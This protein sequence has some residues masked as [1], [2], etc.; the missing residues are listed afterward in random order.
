M[1]FDMT[2]DGLPI[3]VPNDARP[4]Q[5]LGR[6]NRRLQSRRRLIEAFS[7][8][9]RTP[10][11][12]ISQY[13]DLLDHELSRADP[14]EQRQIVRV[15][16]DRAGD[17]NHTFNNLLDA[18]KVDVGKMGS[19]RRTCNPV[20]LTSAVRSILER[21]A[22]ALSRTLEFDFASD[23]APIFCDADQ[24]S[25]VLVNLA[26]DALKGSTS[27]DGVAVWATSNA[28]QSG[29]RVGVTVRRCAGGL[30]PSA[31]N[32]RRE[33]FAG[34]PNTFFGPFGATGRV[35]RAILRRNLTARVCRTSDSE[36]CVSI[37][38]PGMNPEEIV[39]RYLGQKR[40]WSNRET[41]VTFV[42]VAG[43]A[44]RP[45]SPER[46]LGIDQPGR[47][48]AGFG[49]SAE[50]GIVACGLL[51]TKRGFSRFQRTTSDDLGSN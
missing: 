9:V 17:L 12:V 2:N 43:P 35:M 20:D 14:E 27:Q 4:S 22:L 50:C 48:T 8:D 28:A 13:L 10:L 23:L 3:A 25:R 26:V 31:S 47:S 46:G 5:R 37:D 34:A 29:V 32:S 16:R 45:R 30:A 51:S 7:H 41:D 11:T 24:I 18:L 42:E 6:E 40:A 21:K 39:S 1:T 49:A 38:L 36:T 33:L 19:S 15:M 44:G